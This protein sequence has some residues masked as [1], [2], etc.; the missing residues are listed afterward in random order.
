MLTLLLL[1]I[2]LGLLLTFIGGGQAAMDS[3]PVI[4]LHT[5]L[6]PASHG[7]L[8]LWGIDAL[9]T[10]HYLVSEYFQVA[11]ASVTHEDFFK[12]SKVALPPPSPTFSPLLQLHSLAAVSARLISLNCASTG[13]A[14]NSRMGRAFCEE[15]PGVGSADRS[16]DDTHSARARAHGEGQGSREHPEVVCGARP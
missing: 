5:H 7:E 11:P 8:M 3:S 16:R 2:S 9:L 4:D 10:Y 1:M 15:T 6:F 12:M 13:G 14:S